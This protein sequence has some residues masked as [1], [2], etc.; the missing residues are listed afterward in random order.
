MPTKQL[1]AA[2]HFNTKTLILFSTVLTEKHNAMVQYYGK[3]RK[4]FHFHYAFI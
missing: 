1:R 3:G 4:I 2:N